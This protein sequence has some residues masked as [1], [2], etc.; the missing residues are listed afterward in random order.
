MIASRVLGAV[1]LGYAFCAVAVAVSAAG[2]V[3]LGWSRSE[4]VVLSSVLGFVLFL[5]VLLWA[6]SVR[7]LWRLWLLFS[8][9]SLV[10]GAALRWL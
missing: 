5:V 10:G 8:A 2:L 9:G 1:G 4:A 3:A 7:N 6:F